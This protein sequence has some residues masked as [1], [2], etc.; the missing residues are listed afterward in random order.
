MTARV[1]LTVEQ[2]A[3]LK[4]HLDEPEKVAFAYADFADGRFDIAD[5]QPMSGDDV[6]SRSDR[7]VE[8]HDDVRPRLISTASA[9]GLSLVEAHSHGPRGHAAFSPSDLHGFEEWVPH[10]WWRLRGQPYAALVMAGDR[11]DA[12]AWI[13]GPR[14]PQRVAAIEV[15]SR[16]DTRLV[17]PTSATFRTLCGRGLRLRPSA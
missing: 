11:W 6:A 5:L 10:L 17:V 4:Q 9:R 14:D 8:L 1:R 7:H 12:L 13:N 3:V 2:F 16:S 15:T